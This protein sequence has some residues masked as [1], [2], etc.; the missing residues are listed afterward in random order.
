MT[1]NMPLP[2]SRADGD[3]TSAR[4][5]V[6][7]LQPADIDET[8]SKAPVLYDLQGVDSLQSQLTPPATRSTSRLS[9]TN[10]PQLNK[11]PEFKALVRTPTGTTT[12]NVGLDPL[13]TVSIWSLVHPQA[14]ARRRGLTS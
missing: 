5:P 6:V 3:L 10:T 11:E 1:T 2:V 4:D 13:S 7:L 14:E 12:T 8:S 9:R